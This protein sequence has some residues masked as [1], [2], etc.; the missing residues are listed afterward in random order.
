[1]AGLFLNGLAGPFESFTGLFD[2]L[3][4]LGPS[5]P[6]PFCSQPIRAAANMAVS[7]ATRIFRIIADSLPPFGLLGHASTSTRQLRNS[8]EYPCQLRVS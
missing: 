7:R 3:V 5:L 6:G 4:D 1:M 2:R 8:I